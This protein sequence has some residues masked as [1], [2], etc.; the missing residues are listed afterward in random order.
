MRFFSKYFWSDR[1]CFLFNVSCVSSVV[2]NVFMVYRVFHRWFFI[3]RFIGLS[4]CCFL[5]NVSCAY[6]FGEKHIAV[7]TK[8]TWCQR[9]KVVSSVVLN[10]FM[11]YRVFHR[12]FWMF[13]W[14]IVCFLGFLTQPSASNTKVSRYLIL[15]ALAAKAARPLSLLTLS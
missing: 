4:L 9:S 6:I 3:V 11:V 7:P 15:R 12:R 10:V 1:C 14:F 5:F 8:N 13:L 2:L